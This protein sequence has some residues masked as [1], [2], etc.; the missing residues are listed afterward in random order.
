[1]EDTDTTG[2]TEYFPDRDC[3]VDFWEMIGVR[4]GMVSIATFKGTIMPGFE[5]QIWP[6]G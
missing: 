5:F 3:V 2:G 1:M 4:R 6:N